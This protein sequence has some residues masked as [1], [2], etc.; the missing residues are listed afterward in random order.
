MSATPYPFTHRFRV[1][2]S[3][4][5]PQS[6][7]FNSRY[8]EYADLVITEYW[9]E[10]DIHFSGEEALEFHVVK[11]VVEFVQPIRADEW[12]TGK[13][14]TARVGKSSLVTE[15]ALYGVNGEDDLRAT[16]ELV[17]VHVDLATGKSLPVPDSVR[18]RLLG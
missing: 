15:I 4:V 3:E 9:R 12:V 8:L 6:V 1:R 14:R 13:A 11:A 5:D 2:Y 17:N 10:R 18:E 16:I 7:V